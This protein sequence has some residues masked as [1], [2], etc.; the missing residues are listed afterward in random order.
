MEAVCR[1]LGELVEEGIL[2]D[3]AIGGATAAGFHG[4]PFATRDIDVFA[5]ISQPSNSLL[6]T[7]D[8]LYARL[9]EKGFSE[10]DEEGILI[11]DYPVQFI[12]PSPGLEM[13][14][15]KM[16]MVMCW[17]D[18]ELKIISPEYLAAIALKVGRSKDRARLIY[19]FELPVFDRKVFTEIVMKYQLFDKWQSWAKALDLPY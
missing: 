18:L 19:L 1:I 16:A 5:F 3:Y 12:C 7:L 13:E 8:P 15:V 6:I 4:E 17:K 2:E 10:F 11:H 14:A 9:A